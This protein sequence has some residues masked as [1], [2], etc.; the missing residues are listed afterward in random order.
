MSFHLISTRDNGAAVVLSVGELGDC[1]A[2][3]HFHCEPSCEIDHYDDPS[4]DCGD[5]NDPCWFRSNSCE[6]IDGKPCEINSFRDAQDHW[7]DDQITEYY[8]ANGLDAT[9]LYVAAIEAD[10]QGE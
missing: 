8:R 2:T 4:H 7:I 9:L 10:R 1:Y 5:P 6:F 3:V